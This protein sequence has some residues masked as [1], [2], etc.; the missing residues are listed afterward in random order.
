IVRVL[1][2]R[3][4]VEVHA[5]SEQVDVTL[6]WAGGVTSAHRLRRPVARYDQLST[7]PDLLAY[8]DGLRQPGHS[9][10]RIAAQLHRAGLAPPT[11]TERF[12]GETVA[13]LLRRR[14][15]DGPRPRRM[16]GAS[17]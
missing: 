17:A 12:T 7:Y 4:T 11:R 10:A 2:E 3:V 8:I 15:F 1:V 14:G 16:A 9:F 13:R 5:D 6:Q